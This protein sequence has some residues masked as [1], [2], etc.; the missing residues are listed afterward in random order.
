MFAY[1]TEVALRSHHRSARPW[2]AW[3]LVLLGVLS[4][5]LLGYGVFFWLLGLESQAVVI[6]TPGLL[7]TR[8]L[9]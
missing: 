9:A 3:L 1:Q 4:T 5:A 7:L 8:V 6:A 2:A